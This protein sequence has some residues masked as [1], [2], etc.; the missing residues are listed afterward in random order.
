MDI[1]LIVGI[2]VSSLLLVVGAFVVYQTWKRG[3]GSGYA[4][5]L[6]DGLE[7]DANLTPKE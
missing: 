7:W 6:S 4:N 2:C 5:G 1:N 3:Y